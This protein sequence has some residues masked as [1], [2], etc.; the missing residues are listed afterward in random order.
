MAFTYSKLAEVTLASS[1][2]TIAFNNIP[3]NYTDLKVVM[4]TR[5]TYA[6]VSAAL[7][8]SMNGTTSSQSSRYTQGSGSSVVSGNL[9]SNAL[10]G[11]N[12][13]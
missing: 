8:V 10:A 4:S 2:S 11:L 12:T 3:Q 7:F 5:D 6:A 13:G 1:A 9:P